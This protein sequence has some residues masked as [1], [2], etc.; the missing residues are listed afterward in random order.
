MNCEE[1]QKHI[2]ELIDNELREDCDAGVYRHLAE[3]STCRSFHYS[4]LRLKEAV[5]TMLLTETESKLEEGET[6]WIRKYVRIP[7]PVAALYVLLLFG[8]IVGTAFNF[9]HDVAPIVTDRQHIIYIS[10][11][12]EIKIELMTDEIY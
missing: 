3:C 7:L 4:A 2:S 9:M 5:H 12:P 11:Y 8:G 1:Y 10:D 6:H